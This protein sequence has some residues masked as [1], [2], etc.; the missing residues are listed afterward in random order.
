M[1]G[2]TPLVELKRSSPKEGVRIFAKLEGNTPTG[3][4]K[5]RVARALVEDAV[6]SG[7]L[8]PGGTIVEASSGNTGIAVAM[9]ARQLGFDAQIVLP[10]GIVP[11]IFDALNNLWTP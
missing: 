8:K 6:E 11:S 2:Q 5:D 9:V 3:S 7:R 1:V 10:Q 4:I